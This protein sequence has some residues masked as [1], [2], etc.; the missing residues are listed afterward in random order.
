MRQMEFRELIKQLVLLFR[1]HTYVELGVRSGFTF[2]YI[3]PFV[4]RAAACDNGNMSKITPPSS[5][6]EHYNMTTDKM[7]E[8]WKGD[9]D[10][11]FIDACH[12]YEQVMTDFDNFSKFVKPDTGLILLHDTYP[13]NTKLCRPGYCNDAWMAARQIRKYYNKEFEIVTLPG[14]YAGMS[15]IR[16]ATKQLGWREDT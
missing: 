3:A 10:L 7:A 2:N 12:K 8:V 16:K 9:I 13:V 11:L 6:V 14:P 4:E 1:P 15:I 5:V